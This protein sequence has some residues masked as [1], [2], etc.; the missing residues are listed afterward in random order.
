MTK[1]PNLPDEIDRRIRAGYMGF[2][3]YTRELHDR[4][5]ASLL[6][7]KARMVR[8]EVEEALFYGCATW[9]SLKQWKDADAVITVLHKKGDKTE[10]GNYRG[11]SLVSHAGKVL[12]EVVA[13]RL[14]A[15]CEAKGLLPEE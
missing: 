14:S 2:K 11:I 8:S 15:Y 5:K 7:L 9:T 3:R 13:R 1:T 6:T 12:L 4:L 10:C